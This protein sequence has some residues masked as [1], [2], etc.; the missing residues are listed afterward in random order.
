MLPYH[1]SYSSSH[2]LKMIQKG[3]LHPG[4]FLEATCILE[5]SDMWKDNLSVQKRDLR[6]ADSDDL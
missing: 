5:P 4:V 6:A 2:S 1:L 3:F